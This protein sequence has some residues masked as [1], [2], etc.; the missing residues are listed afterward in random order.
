MFHEHTSGTTGK[1]LDLWC[2]QKTVRSWY[3]LFE[4][5]CRIWHSVDRHDRW[6]I[7]GGQMITPAGQRQPPFWVWNAGLKQL[8]LSSYHLAPD[9]IPHYIEAIQ[10]YRVS[11]LLGYT[12]ALYAL[13][14]GVL[15]LGRRDVKMRVAI[16][17][18]EPLYEYQRQTIEVAFNCRVR[19]TYGMA[20]IVA[21]AGE[22]EAG[23]MHIW[24]EAG[25]IETLDNGQPAEPGTPGDLVCTSLINSDMPLVR[26]RVGDRGV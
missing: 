26:Y 5:R 18:A 3:A 24:P 4:A 6:G 13:A 7:L 22:C 25:R 14:Q 23:R 10:R 1:S 2:S 8:Y 9:L 19:E 12:S 15:L 17:N 11:Y 20:E 16:S 21:A